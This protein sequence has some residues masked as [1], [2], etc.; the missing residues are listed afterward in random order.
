MIVQHS[1]VRTAA[2]RSPKACTRPGI[3]WDSATASL[4]LPTGGK[5]PTLLIHNAHTLLTQDDT[6]SEL[7]H[8]SLWVRDNRIE[9]LGAAAPPT[10]HHRPCWPMR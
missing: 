7:Q 2:W 1:P 3:P 5:M 8:A 9:W 10:C 6:K 4:Y